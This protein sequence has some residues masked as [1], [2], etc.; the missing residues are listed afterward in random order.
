[1]S[2]SNRGFPLR[3]VLLSALA[4]LATVAVYFGATGALAA[5]DLNSARAHAVAA[6]AALQ[7]GDL[8]TLVN[9]IGHLRADL[10]DAQHWVSAPAWRVAAALPGVGSR[11]D[12]PLRIIDVAGDLAQSS[13]EFEAVARAFLATGQTGFGPPIP[14]SILE[15]FG[16]ALT[17]LAGSAQRAGDQLKDINAAALPEPL[18][19]KFANV[20]QQ[21]ATVLPPL[22]ALA[23]PAESLVALL[24]P[25]GPQRWFVAMQNGGESRG[26][27]G[28]VGAFAELTFDHGKVEVDRIGSDRELTA[29]A[30]PTL[31][32]KDSQ[33]LWSPARLAEQY[34]VNLSPNFPYAGQLLA[35][36][37]QH[38]SGHA[39]D[40]VAALDQR[41]TAALIGAVGG[42]T[43]DGITLTG[44]NAFDYLTVGV[45]IRFPDVAEK[46][47]FVGKVIGE[48]MAR[49]KSGKVPMTKLAGIF[50]DATLNRS[51]FLWAR[52]PA[53]QRPLAESALGGVVPDA[54]G[55]LAMAVVN[56]NAGNKMDTFLHTSVRYSQGD[57]VA[58][59]RRSTLSV[60]LF[61][62]P[63][64]DLP[65]YVGGR[66]DRILLQGLS[67][68]GDGS[69]RV[70]LATYLPK[71]AYFAGSTPTQLF[72]GQEREH[73]VA[74]FGVELK[75]GEH[76]TITVDFTEFG[77]PDLI[78]R[79][80]VVLPQPMLNQQ[81][82][83]TSDGP[84]C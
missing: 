47:A 33:E 30:D 17:T 23:A 76:K 63:P 42:V 28:F 65:N 6:D 69:T 20:Q 58:G 72:T 16:Q 55:P 4:T 77:G 78:N 45:Y 59:G 84:R 11:L 41:T 1:M 32:P 57:C 8:P 53:T 46:N 43:V 81:Q 31:L 73:P 68:V 7:T 60:E 19:A 44:E 14:R 48:T 56:N 15:G 75:R 9:Q 26:T 29:K 70:R 3:V 80:P 35:S 79:K 61:N 39:P 82:L 67:G 71:G 38:Q 12:P 83:E 22:I 24:G 34:G 49:I 2:R 74:M 13:A 36:L 5:A 52:D 18:A 25:N 40:A 50:L 10:I 21:L 66:G 51:F 64:A 54:G 27:G 62:D 37:W